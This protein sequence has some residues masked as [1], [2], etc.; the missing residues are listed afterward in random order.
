MRESLTVWVCWIERKQ[1]REAFVLTNAQMGRIACA[2]ASPSHANI[3]IP[4]IL[5]CHSFG[6][7]WCTLVPLLSTA[8]VTG[9]ST[10]SNS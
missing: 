2:A 4:A 9:I 7:V 3:G 5:A 10:T 1:S 6:P 8:T